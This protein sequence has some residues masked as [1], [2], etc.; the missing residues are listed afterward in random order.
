[1]SLYRNDK[2][3][4]QLLD[5]GVQYPIASVDTLNLKLILNQLVGSYKNFIA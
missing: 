3:L 2:E 4:K 1:M 5:L